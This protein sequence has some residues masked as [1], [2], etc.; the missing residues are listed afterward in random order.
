MTTTD[1]EPTITIVPVR[2]PTRAEKTSPRSEWWV[3]R[4]VARPIAGVSPARAHAR[5]DGATDDKQRLLWWVPEEGR[6]PT[7]REWRDMAHLCEVG[8]FERLPLGQVGEPVQ[9]YAGDA[10][11]DALAYIDGETKL[12]RVTTTRRTPHPREW[13]KILIVP[14]PEED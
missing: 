2:E 11:A 10:E 3:Y 7:S 12:D 14:V 6:P 13:V 4:V 8:A 5:I 1:D 9:G